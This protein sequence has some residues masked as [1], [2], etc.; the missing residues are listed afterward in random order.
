MTVLSRRPICSH[1]NFDLISFGSSQVLRRT[2]GHVRKSQRCP[3]TRWCTLTHTHTHTHT[4]LL[5]HTHTHTQTVPRGSLLASVIQAC[6]SG[7]LTLVSA[8]LPEPGLGMI[9]PHTH[10]H[11][12]TLCSI[13]R[14]T[15]LLGLQW[16][17]W[18]QLPS[19]ETRSSTDRRADRHRWNV[20]SQTSSKLSENCL[21]IKW[22]LHAFIHSS[23]HECYF[24]VFLLYLNFLPLNVAFQLPLP[25][26][27]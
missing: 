7:R 2:D 14:F 15:A 6:V 24:Q 11:T 26:Y 3:P 8:T 19:S 18:A 23:S 10:T 27:S 21:W 22:D 9:S 16:P 5:T 17:E 25:L 4:P 1:Y 20:P 12:H 13:Y